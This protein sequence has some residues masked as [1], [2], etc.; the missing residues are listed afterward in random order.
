MPPKS[1]PPVDKKQ[2]TLFGF[3][4]KAPPSS[5]PSVRPAS[6]GAAGASSPA[7]KPTAAASSST[8]PK[9][10]AA[11]KAAPSSSSKNL[12][13]SSS[14]L[15]RSSEIQPLRKK[16][17]PLGAL[18]PTPASSAASSAQNGALVD[19]SE[20][21]EDDSESA[22]PTSDL[23]PSGTTDMDV[24]EDEDEH[25]V[26]RSVRPKI[27]RPGRRVRA[28]QPTAGLHCDSWIVSAGLTFRPLRL[29]LPLLLALLQVRVKRKAAIV[30]SD[31]SGTEDE[32]AR[33]KAKAAGKGAAKKPRKSVPES[34]DEFELD[35]DDE[36][37]IGRFLLSAPSSET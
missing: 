18:L 5:S 14:P 25:P 28:R 17:A 26:G 32:A 20:D 35:D 3:F 29:S 11:P 27:G 6:N 16:L 37:L 31:L 24:D 34:D 13:A 2:T 4:N 33:P 23:P 1:T 10:T 15:N 9:A 22:A 19:L 8:K 36:E 12:P 21:G 7:V 30:E